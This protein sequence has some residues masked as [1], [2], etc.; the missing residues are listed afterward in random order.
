MRISTLYLGFI[1]NERYCSIRKN[2]QETESLKCLMHLIL[3]RCIY[4]SCSS[5]LGIHLI[6]KL[7]LNK[8]KIKCYLRRAHSQPLGHHNNRIKAIRR[9]KTHLNFHSANC[10]QHAYNESDQSRSIN[11]T[12]W[13]NALSF[14]EFLYCRAPK[15]SKL[16]EWKCGIH[17]KLVL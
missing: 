12:E 14:P 7:N 13:K 11:K 16:L 1:P 9:Y 3:G 5:E 17:K 15:V 2:I 8:F 4:K 10:G 6:L